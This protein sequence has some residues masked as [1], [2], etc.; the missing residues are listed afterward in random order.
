MKQIVE[1]IWFSVK[2]VDFLF[3]LWIDYPNNTLISSVTYIS[4]ITVSQ[5]I[6]FDYNRFSVLYLDYWFLL[7]SYKRTHATRSLRTRNSFLSSL[8][9]S[10]CAKPTVHDFILTRDV[11]R[12]TLDSKTPE[13]SQVSEKR[14]PSLGTFTQYIMF[15]DYS[16]L[17]LMIYFPYT[18]PVTLMGLS[19][20]GEVI[21]WILTMNW[22]TCF[23]R[24]SNF[25][26]K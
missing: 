4:R 19:R 13:K 1:R 2:G 6:T 15:T 14:L 22:M 20:K 11:K 18:P 12:K 25:F 10:L 8:Q 17:E 21:K 26:L 16:P 7:I 5:V 24:N 3:Q 23:C 9:I